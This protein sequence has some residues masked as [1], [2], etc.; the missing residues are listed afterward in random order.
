M[1]GA[2]R[3]FLKR[4]NGIAATELALVTPVFLLLFLSMIELGHMIYYS[5]TV[6]KALRSAATFVGRNEELTAAVITATENVAMTGDPAGGGPYLVPGWADPVASV[7]VT[8]SEFNANMTGPG[9]DIAETVYTVTV[10]V[11]YV[12]VVDVLVPALEYLMRTSFYE[13]KYMII[14]THEQA[15][16]GD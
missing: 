12:P 9:E 14:L 1:I 10:S 11:P 16:I 3:R 8:E 4:E 5:V 2:I 7:T 15:M 6:E 13:G